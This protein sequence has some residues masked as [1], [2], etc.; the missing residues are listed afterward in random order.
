MLQT[1][2]ITVAITW[3]A[4][5]TSPTARYEKL[6]KIRHIAR[7]QDFLLQEE[8][9]PIAIAL[10]STP[11]LIFHLGFDQTNLA[12][13]D[14]YHDCKHPYMEGIGRILDHL[15]SWE[16]VQRLEFLIATGEDPMLGLQVKLDRESH[17][18]SQKPSTL[19]GN[20]DSQII[21]SFKR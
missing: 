3:S 19:C 12:K 2:V 4:D 13:P 15:Q 14:W 6:D 1:Y 7:S 21:Y 20:L 18:L 10:F 16:A 11:S 8:A 9:R 17:S 5:L